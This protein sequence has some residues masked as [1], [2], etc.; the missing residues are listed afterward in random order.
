M[1][2]LLLLPQCAATVGEEWVA[3][4]L[5]EAISR[6][7]DTTVI[8]MRRHADPVSVADLLPLARVFECEAWPTHR[9]GERLNALIKPSYVR[10]H[11]FARSEL[12]RLLASEHFD[13]A[14][15]I[16][17]VGMRYPTPL[18]RFPVPYVIGP[19]GGAL[20]T[21][22]AFREDNGVFPW[23]YRLRNL[24]QLRLAFDPYL[25]RSYERAAAVVG[26]APYVAQI[27]SQ[28]TI[29]RLE[30]ASESAL[31]SLPS[32]DTRQRDP[33]RFRL[34]HISRAIRTKGLLYIVQA[35]AKLKD[36]PGLHL[37]AVGDGPDLEV[38][39]SLARELGVQDAIT[40]HGQKPHADL[41]GF[42]RNGDL[43][44]HPS[45]REAGGVA[46]FEALGYGL[47]IICADYG[48]PGYHVKDSFGISVP[49]TSQQAFVD[50]IASAIRQLYSDPGRLAA[51][52]RAARQEIEQKHLWSSR[53][54]F[55]SELYE[56]IRSQG[57]A[58]RARNPLSSTPEDNCRRAS[59]A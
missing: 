33:Q 49:V 24:D 42:Y 25:R 54:A 13:I 35:M 51:M 29:E 22:V 7:F 2:I 28:M 23:Y 57:A 34:L 5:A 37:D 53:V 4:K 16:G 55:F 32:L 19:V 52:S 30:Y 11:L 9:L 59:G 41:D 45:F 6:E 14:H 17:P 15:Q 1:K 18:S 36:L 8:A 27:L 58:Q 46:P 26:I 3:Y 50:G 21:P 39:R 20:P 44:V 56:S 43:F 47:P 38:C 48:A 10:F 31:E 40:F 12:R